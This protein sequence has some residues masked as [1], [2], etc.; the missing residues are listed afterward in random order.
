MPHGRRGRGMNET[1]R[2]DKGAMHPETQVSCIPRGCRLPEL[3]CIAARVQHS[4]HL[5]GIWQ[6]PRPWIRRGRIRTAPSGGHMRRARGA[7]TAQPWS[8]R[9]R[10]TG[11]MPTNT[12][13]EAT[14]QSCHLLYAC[15]ELS[16]PFILTQVQP[17]DYSRIRCLQGAVRVRWSRWR[18]T[19]AL[20]L[21]TGQA[22]RLSVA[23][24]S[25]P[26]RANCVS[27]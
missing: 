17:Y 23:E 26:P 8:Q 12:W 9:Q 20:A 1:T 27:S 22:A 15:A 16:T 13:G 11:R 6:A 3:W 19:W 4:A 2:L 7:G 25:P 14:E 5:L 21:L 24:L 10:A 18:L